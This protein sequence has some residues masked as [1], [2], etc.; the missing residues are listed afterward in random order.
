LKS[1]ENELA[2]YNLFVAEIADK[3]KRERI[4]FAIV[5]NAYLSKE[6]WGDLVDGGMALRGRAS[7]EIPIEIRNMSPYKIYGIPEMFEI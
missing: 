6:P 2:S 7:Y 5:Q 1:V 4:E 3:R